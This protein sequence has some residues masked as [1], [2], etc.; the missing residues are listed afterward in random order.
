MET[1]EVFHHVEKGK[2]A[3]LSA[4]LIDCEE[5]DKI[6]YSITEA[7]CEDKGSVDENGVYTAPS[8]AESGDIVAVRASLQS[9]PSVFAVSIIYIS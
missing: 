2:T 3:K 4:K 5:T 7:T 6:V 9:D 8:T 1:D